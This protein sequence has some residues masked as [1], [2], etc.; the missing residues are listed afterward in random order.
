MTGTERGGVRQLKLQ[1]LTPQALVFE[2]RVETVVAPLPDGWIGVLPGHT[3]FQARLMRGLVVFEASGRR[4]TIATIGG[5]ISVADDTVTV[6][7]GAAA[8]D[9]DLAD[10]EREIG[11]E[12]AQ[13]EEIERE[14]EKHF[15]RVYRALARTFNG[16]GGYA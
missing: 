7:T 14:A 4:R 11:E 5:I 10:L 12:S 15:D 2:E 16:R 9:Q 3:A 8:V 1:V 6:L 13:I